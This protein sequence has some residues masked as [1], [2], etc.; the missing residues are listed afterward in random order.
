VYKVV[1]RDGDGSSGSV[2][3]ASGAVERGVGQ[4]TVVTGGS[5]IHAAPAAGSPSATAT[6]PI[7]DP[8]A[9]DVIATLTAVEGDLLGDAFVLRAG[10]NHLG[11]GVDCSIVLNSPWIS[12]SHAKIICENGQILIRA[13]EGKG[14]W[15]DDAQIVEKVL[16]DGARIRL[17][18]TILSLRTVD[19]QQ[20]PVSSVIPVT[21][22][23]SAASQAPQPAAKLPTPLLP[24][25]APAPVPPAPVAA[26]ATNSAP[27]PLRKKS[28]WRFWA[29]PVPTLVF[30][31][32]DRM[33]DR[34]ELTSARF[35]IGG[36][37]DNDI[38]ISG[39]DASRNHAEL[40]IRDGRV[41]IWDL[42][43]VNGTWVNDER[44]ENA[45]LRFGD[46]I[47]IGSEELRY[48]D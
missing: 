39:N 14:V 19:V 47:R 46:V 44:I 32:G 5:Q 35:R 43:S 15:V 4:S 48:E 18:T 24:A 2:P 3:Q 27:P 40:R 26:R 6:S 13:T 45:E 42:R 10:E 36:L 16:L 1:T 17:G 37:E 29:K 21:P 38:V 12:R 33:G 20:K 25:P 23:S 31:T 9:D 11:R 8:N 7:P 41:H 28:W 22:N 34:I 30:V